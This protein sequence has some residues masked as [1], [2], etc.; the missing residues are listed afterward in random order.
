MSGEAFAC[1]LAET[2]HLPKEARRWICPCTGAGLLQWHNSSAVWNE[3][4]LLILVYAWKMLLSYGEPEIYSEM[5]YFIRLSL[6]ESTGIRTSVDTRFVGMAEGAKL[7]FSL[8]QTCDLFY[9]KQGDNCSS[10][11]NRTISHRSL[12]GG[13]GHNV[14]HIDPVVLKNRHLTYPHLHL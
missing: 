11:Y 2:R 13:T 14:Q 4:S 3:P 5:L 9:L 10:N 7:N 6:L 8:K 12:I 1:P